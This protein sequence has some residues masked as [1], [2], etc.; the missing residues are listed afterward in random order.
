MKISIFGLGY[1]GSVSLAC[2]ARDGHQVIGVDV[3]QSKLDMIGSGKTPVVEEGMIE[4]MQGVVSSGLIAVT[5]DVAA[6]LAK[7]G[8]INDLCR[9]PV[10]SQRQSGSECNAAPGKAVGRG[11]AGK[12]C[13]AYVCFPLHTCPGYG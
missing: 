13:G 10:C 9:D 1:V 12:I 3:D 4:L 5:Q 8:D 6:A 7:F 2:L 11:D